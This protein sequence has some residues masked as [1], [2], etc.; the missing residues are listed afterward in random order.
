MIIALVL[1]SALLHATWNALLRLEREKD[2]ALVV[3]IAIATLFALAIAGARWAHGELPF[4]SWR[5]AGFTLLA[6][7]AEAVY[8]ATLAR[9]MD[10]GRLGVVYTVS[11][12]G[13]VLVVW[14]LSILWFAE[15]VT[16]PS[17][18][19]SVVVLLGLVCCGAGAGAGRATAE[20][21]DERAAVLWAVACAGSIALYHL[22]YKA[23]LRA[24]VNPSACFGCSLG[25]SALLN[26]ARLGGDGRRALGPLL[27]ARWPRL[28]A[29]GVVC[30]GSFL[31]LMEALARGGSGF[32]LTLRNTSVLFAAVMSAMIGERPRRLELIGAAL[33]AAGATLM[34]LG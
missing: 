17:I 26:V 18:G 16:A 24:D 2:R 6:G 20:N 8:F 15:A 10:K 27:R 9:A 11:R 31:I 28:L 23:A 22:S 32:V 7:L 30:G 33:V 1:F 25:V 4:G 13:A 29:M 19:G 34:A 21:R 3:A 5:G 14:P 12:G